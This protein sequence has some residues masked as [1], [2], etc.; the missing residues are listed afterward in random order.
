MNY[1]EWETNVPETLKADGLWQ[2][3]AYRLGK[4]SVDLGWFDVTK[5]MG[6]RRTLS[7]S[8]QLYAA[9]GSISANLAEGYSYSTGKNRARMYEY[10]LGSARESREWYYDGRHV[11]GDAVMNHRLQL[12][13][14]IIRLLIVMIP[15]QRDRDRIHPLH[16][17]GPAYRVESHL[18]ESGQP[19]SAEELESLLQ[20][21]PLP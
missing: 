6:D 18:I 12:L 2:V 1:A 3:K 19:L 11:L 9:L 8:D 4:F 13:S 10:A 14:E 16:E 20:N 21:V 17:T 15:D 7:L 5:L